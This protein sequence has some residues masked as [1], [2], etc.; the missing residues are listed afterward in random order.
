MD[1]GWLLHQRV[2]FIRQ[3]YVMSAVPYVGER[4]PRSPIPNNGN[5]REPR[6]PREWMAWNFCLSRGT[7]K[8]RENCTRETPW[9][10]WDGPY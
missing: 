1:V 5:H 4:K 2:G 10:V 8:L 6:D 9:L 3:L 7:Q